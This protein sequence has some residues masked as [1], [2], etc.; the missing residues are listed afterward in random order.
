MTRRTNNPKKKCGYKRCKWPRVPYKKYCAQHV[1]KFL[2]GTPIIRTFSQI[3][4]DNS[5]SHDPREP[6]LRNTNGFDCP[7][8][9]GEKSTLKHRIK[10]FIFK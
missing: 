9:P 3:I 8:V 4:K 7:P 5:I 2:E 10:R 6:E 1:D